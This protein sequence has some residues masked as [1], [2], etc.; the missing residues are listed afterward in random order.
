[1]RVFIVED[2]LIHL[3]AI[4]IAIEEAGLELA[5]ECGNAD[6]AFDLIGKTMPDVLLVDIALPG[7]LNGITL[8]EKVHNE[9]NIPHIFTTSFTSD[10]VI[11]QAVKTNP[12]GYLRKPVDPVNLKATVL[13]AVQKQHEDKDEKAD[14]STN[15]VFTRIGD[16]L[17]RV[18]IDE[19]LM[20]K[21]DGENCIS[22]VLEKKEISCRT[23]LK[24]F[25]K[26]LPPNFIQVHRGYVINI[27]HLDSFNEREQTAYLKNHNAPVARNFRKDFLNSIR[28]V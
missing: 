28:K 26:Q 8:A 25:C 27:D 22:L 14:I 15:S 23:T 24:E 5:G 7:L 12:A 20:V 17:V 4:K 9:L 3:E 18:N 10:E 19:I 1:M 13:L 11:C 21:A 16:K 6:L 2:E